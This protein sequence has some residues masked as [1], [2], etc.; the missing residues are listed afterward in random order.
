MWAGMSLVW[1]GRCHRCGHRDVTCADTEMSPVRAGRCHLCKQGDVTGAG[2]EQPF[3]PEQPLP[4]QP[5][6]A[7]PPPPAGRQGRA[8][9]C[10]A[11]PA[12][13]GT[14]EPSLGASLPMGAQRV[15]RSRCLSVRP[16][17]APTGASPCS[18]PGLA[19]SR[20]PRITAALPARKRLGF[21]LWCEKEKYSLFFHSLSFLLRPGRLRKHGLTVVVPVC[22]SFE[23][24]QNSHIAGKFQDTDFFK[25]DNQST[26]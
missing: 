15:L 20:I 25:S 24:S 13:P 19:R 7:A 9:V 17:S 22:L 4:E 14:A 21:K 16:R 12:P 8:E 18:P 1:A 23:T 26:H 3:L 2:T 11:G 6:R 5:P 10:G